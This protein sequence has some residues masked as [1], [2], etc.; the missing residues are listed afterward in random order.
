MA[1]A[2]RFLTS[3]L[4]VAAGLG[5]D[6]LS[7]A[8]A[9]DALARRSWA[10]GRPAS[11]VLQALAGDLG[12]RLALDSELVRGGHDRSTIAP[13]ELLEVAKLFEAARR[14]AAAD[15]LAA[16]GVAPELDQGTATPAARRA[17]AV[18]F[19]R[20]YDEGLIDFAPAVVPYCP[21]CGTVI[22]GP[23]AVAAEIDV[24]LVT[25]RIDGLDTELAATELVDGAVAIAVPIGDGAAGRDVALPLA[26]REV[27]VIEEPGCVAPR[28]VVPAHDPGSFELARLHGLVPRA[29]LGPDGVVLGDGPLAGLSRFA[30][31]QAARALLDAEDV[32]V[33]V[34][35]GA[36][37][38]DRCRPCGSVAVS[39]LDS[40]WMLRVAELEVAAADAIRHDRVA[41]VPGDVRDTVLAL[42]GGEPWCLDRSVPGGVP[43]PVAT[44]REC[45]RTTVG[46][47]QPTACGKCFGELEPSVLTLDARFVAA[48]SPLVSA[49]WPARVLRTEVAAAGTTV[50]V[51]P[52][53]ALASWALPALALGL[54]LGGYAPFGSVVVQPPE[55]APQALYDIGAG[56]HLD[57]RVERL[58]LLAGV[59]LDTAFAAVAALDDP[60]GDEAHAEDVLGTVDA[61]VTALDDLGPRRAAALLAAALVGG[62]PA[63]IADRLRALVVPFLGA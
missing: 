49:E 29:V 11:V 50:A 4:P 28:L 57:A 56:E 52:P 55:P 14:G 1:D 18:A 53:T 13:A 30:A 35:D 61:A 21:S 58:V 16:L 12:G 24:E 42:A 36:E 10:T 43:L 44:C 59:D 31:R 9:A 27:P 48:L 17:A 34:R 37:L 41:F 38:V 20:L 47:D 7:A 60:T 15:Q 6:D 33:A 45:L 40:H 5:P 23:D 22:E 62:V 19:V 63:S 25:V 51:T 39:V 54:H 26:A 32:V 3:P 46:V 2:L 8:V